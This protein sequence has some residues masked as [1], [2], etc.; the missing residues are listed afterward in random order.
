[1]EFEAA[2]GLLIDTRQLFAVL[3][4]VELGATEA[5]EVRQRLRTR[6]GRWQESSSGA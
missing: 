4:Q 6:R 2:G 3:K 1:V 5:H